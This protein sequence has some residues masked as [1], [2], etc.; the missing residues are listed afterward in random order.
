[1]PRESRIPRASTRSTHRMPR[2]YR[3]VLK[4]AAFGAATDVEPKSMAHS[5]LA[6]QWMAA[7]GNPVFPAHSISNLMDADSPIRRHKKP[8]AC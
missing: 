3:D 7:R 4:E 6:S 5:D 1:M 8:H 2:A